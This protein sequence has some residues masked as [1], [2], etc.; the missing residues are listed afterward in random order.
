MC[1]KTIEEDA[2]LYCLTNH[3]R[4]YLPQAHKKLCISLHCTMY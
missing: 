4:S 3:A 2:V 1:V